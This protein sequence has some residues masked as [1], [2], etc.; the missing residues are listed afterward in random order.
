M[1]KKSIND[2][3]KTSFYHAKYGEYNIVEYFNCEKVKIKFKNT[4]YEYFTSMNHIEN[5][6]VRDKLYKNIF[7]GFTG[8]S[9]Y[10][11]KMYDIW[12]NMLYRAN[13]IGGS[14]SDVCVCEEW[15]CFKNFL[16]WAKKQ[17]YESGWHLDK[18][19]LVRG[20]RVYSPATCCFVPPQINTFFEKSNKA[21]GY[22]FNRSKTK[23]V[24]FIRSKGKK[25]HLGTFETKEEAKFT[26]LKKKQELLNDLIDEYKDCLSEKVLSSL[27]KYYKNA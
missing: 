16:D 17:K 15:L 4:G 10:D 20:N 21:A 11:S 3:Q 8:T 24:S 6:E 12:Y 7:G 1:L 5:G 13:R 25:I 19:I 9:D 27:K 26:Y 18:D 14:Y 23:Y 22:G 2:L